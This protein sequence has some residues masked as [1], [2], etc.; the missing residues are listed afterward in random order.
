MLKLEWLLAKLVRVSPLNKCKQPQVVNL[1][2]PKNF[3]QWDCHKIFILSFY[4]IISEQNNFNYFFFVKKENNTKILLLFKKKTSPFYVFWPLTVWILVFWT[5]KIQH[6][7]IERGHKR[8][9][10]LKLALNQENSWKATLKMICPGIED[11]VCSR[12]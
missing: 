6:R 5:R 2:F 10:W 7:V 9:Q 12:I 3:N 11:Q 1:T 4:S 8:V